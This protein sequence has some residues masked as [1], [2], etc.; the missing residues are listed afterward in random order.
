MAGALFFDAES[1]FRNTSLRSNIDSDKIIPSI[2]WVHNVKF[3][4]LLGTKL[5]EKLDDLVRTGVDASNTG[6]FAPE[7]S[8]YYR[9]IW[10]PTSKN[11]DLTQVGQHWAAWHYLREGGYTIDNKGNY[12]EGAQGGSV[13]ATDDEVQKLMNYA[14]STAEFY[15]ARLEDHI[16]NNT[17][18]YPE[19]I[20]SEAEDLPPTSNRYSTPWV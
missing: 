1:V 12:K 18:L 20:T 3:V 8:N 13:V 15:W 14:K 2:E 10:Q 11:R 17:G 6:I 5:M 7:N 19:Y 16:Q 4:D 9:L